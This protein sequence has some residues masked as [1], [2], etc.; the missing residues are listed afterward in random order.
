MTRR[1]Q[2]TISKRGD[3]YAA[4]AAGAETAST[5]GAAQEVGDAGSAYVKVDITAVT[6]TTPTMLGF[7]EGSD[8][9]ATWFTIARIG[10]NGYILGDI[11]TD[12]TN[13]TTP[14]TKRAVVPAA[15]FMR[16]RSVIGGTTPSFTYSV[17]IEGNVPAVS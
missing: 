7:I 14:S 8:D 2:G 10:A 11:G 12:P 6:G 9:G 16:W 17:S 15:Q 1:A 3:A 13:F 4:K 5:T